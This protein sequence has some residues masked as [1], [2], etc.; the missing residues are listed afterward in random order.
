M[1]TV[2][3]TTRPVVGARVNVRRVW[4]TVLSVKKLVA[5]FK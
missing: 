5:L 2:A 1:P 3:S 4:F